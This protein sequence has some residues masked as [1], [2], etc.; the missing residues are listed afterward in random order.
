MIYDTDVLEGFQPSSRKHNAL[1]TEKEAE[2]VIYNSLP[3][4]LGP[5]HQ[6]STTISSPSGGKF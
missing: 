4:T 6:Q 5:S 1:F 2:L 3:E